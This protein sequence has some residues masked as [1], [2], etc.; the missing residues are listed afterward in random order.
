MRH[1]AAR[2]P[3]S[4]QQRL[5][6][7]VEVGP[8]DP[9]EAVEGVEVVVI[10]AAAI[11]EGFDAGDTF[12]LFDVLGYSG[13]EDGPDRDL[14]GEGWKGFNVMLEH[15]KQGAIGVFTDILVEG[16]ELDGVVDHTPGA[17]GIIGV[18]PI[19]GQAFFR[20]G[21]AGVRPDLGYI[22]MGD[23]VGEVFIVHDRIDAVFTV[24]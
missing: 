13:G 5:D 11:E 12:G 22:V 14:G 23:V 9:C 21:I 16:M 2:E 7:G 24:A 1:R 8:V 6:A 4:Q 3:L 19:V 17:I 10:A 18:T 15:R 20:R